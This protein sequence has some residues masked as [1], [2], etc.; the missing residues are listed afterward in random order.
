[1]DKILIIDDSTVQANF[2]E[3]ILSDDY[4]VTKTHTAKDGLHLAQIEDYSLILLDVIMPDMDGFM[5]LKELQETFITKNIPVILITSLSD[6]QSEEKGLVLGAVDYITKPFHPLIVKARVNTHIKLWHYRKQIEKQALVDE[7]TGIAN[8][9][10]Y[11][12]FIMTKWQ[13]AIRLK[14]SVSICMFDIDNFKLYNDTYGHPAGDKVIAAVAKT[15]SSYLKRTTDFFA[16]YG[17]EEFIAIILGSEAKPAFEHLKKIRGAIEN[18]KIPHKASKHNH[19]TVSIG[20]ITV[21]PEHGYS[22][23]TYLKLSDTMLYDAKRLGRN[24]VV[25]SS[26]N[27]EQWIEK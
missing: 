24:M 23:D 16:R 7:L 9:R 8:R 26:G 2:L 27:A 12:N 14:H 22:Y 11:D 6:I 17:G 10:S 18:L 15:A 1:M 20:G 21:V 5:L 13:E 4:E 3:S 19:V 25:W